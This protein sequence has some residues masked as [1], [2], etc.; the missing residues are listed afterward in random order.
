MEAT[1]AV[2][3]P[4]QDYP[5]PDAL[6][7]YTCPDVCDRTRGLMPEDD[8]HRIHELTGHDLEVGMTEACRGD[9]HEDFAWA[10]TIA[11]D[12]LDLQRLAGRVENR[13]TEP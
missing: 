6:P 11:R 4:R 9:P 3:I 1:T 12:F 2:R 13:C 10:G 5:L 8:G 7:S